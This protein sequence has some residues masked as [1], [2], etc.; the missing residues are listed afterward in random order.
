VPSVTLPTTL[1]Y[2]FGLPTDPQ[3]GPY[4]TSINTTTGIV[5]ITLNQITAG[6]QST[7]VVSFGDGAANQTISALS[8][9]NPVSIN[10]TYTASGTYI[11]SGTATPTGLTDINTTVVPMTVTVPVVA[12]YNGNSSYYC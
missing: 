5:T 9:G 2:S 11:I 10:H 7:V 1:T 3:S 4:N 6:P 8:A 12:I